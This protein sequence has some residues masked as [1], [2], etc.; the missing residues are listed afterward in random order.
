MS[1]KRSK[2]RSYSSRSRDDDDPGGVPS[3]PERSWEDQ[4]QGQTD[5]VFVPYSVSTRFAKGGFLLHPKFGKGVVVAVDGAHVDVLFAEGKKK[6][7]HGKLEAAVMPPKP[8]R[9]VVD[10]PAE[11]EEADREAPAEPADKT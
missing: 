10:V 11:P 4:I 7:G 9:Q 2:Q 1:I 5:D 6:L 3:T 8:R